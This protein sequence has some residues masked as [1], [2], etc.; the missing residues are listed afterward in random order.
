MFRR[1]L[2]LV[3]LLA[4]VG[5]LWWRS[6]EPSHYSEW[7]SDAQSAPERALLDHPFA[8]SSAVAWVFTSPGDSVWRVSRV[9]DGLLRYRVMMLHRDSL[10]WRLYLDTDLDGTC[11]NFALLTQGKSIHVEPRGDSAR[12]VALGQER[13]EAWIPWS[14]DAVPYDA[15][16]A[17]SESWSP[18]AERKLTIVRIQPQS[19]VITQLPALLKPGTDSTLQLNAAGKELVTLQYVSNRIVKICLAGGRC[20][21]RQGEPAS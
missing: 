20:L 10:N 5:Y 8:D 13:T 12:F 11:R 7:T 4:A 17:L 6:R 19:E 1:Q 15:I 21:E 14:V 9:N 16:P 18:G 2:I 3:L